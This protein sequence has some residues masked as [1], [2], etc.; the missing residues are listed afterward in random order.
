MINI[1]N[2]KNG[3]NQDFMLS[4]NVENI[5]NKIIS[6]FGLYT[7][8]PPYDNLITPLK[9]DFSE[10][11]KYLENLQNFVNTD[12]KTPF[13]ST[14]QKLY[15]Y[16]SLNVKKFMDAH[17]YRLKATGIYFNEDCRKILD[18]IIE[19]YRSIHAMILNLLP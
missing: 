13:F 6:L 10:L 16:Y 12:D 4:D 15:E 7:T 2:S 3:W 5:Y 1:M 17:A 18:N 11:L 14:L 9:S 8:I 19:K